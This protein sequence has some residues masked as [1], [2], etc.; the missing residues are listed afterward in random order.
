MGFKKRIS[1]SET[2]EGIWRRRF[3]VGSNR[4]KLKTGYCFGAILFFVVLFSASLSA[5][6]DITLAWD[7]NSESDVA[8]YKIYYRTG[9]SGSSVMANYN[10]G[11][12]E[13]GNSPINLPA[14]EDKNLDPRFVEIDL[15]GLDENQDYYFVVTAYNTSGIESGPSNEAA[16]VG[17]VAT[18]INSRQV[19]ASGSGG[20][21]GGG[22]GGCFI[23]TL[24]GE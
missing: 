13:E 5:A 20:G 22:G 23:S 16:L 3:Q 9:S 11:G 17:G 21:G 12:I 24:T 8:G 2:V 7:Q 15:H 19:A 18:E 4:R 1:V 6:D 10:G 14:D